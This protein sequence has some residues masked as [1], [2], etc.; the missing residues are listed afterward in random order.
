M[1]NGLMSNSNSNQNNSNKV[2]IKYRFP[3]WLTIFFLLLIL[4]PILIFSNYFAAAKL[5]GIF[6]LILVILALRIWLRISRINSSKVERLVL[7]KNQTFDLER[8]YPFLRTLK[9]VNRQIL[10]HRTGLVLAELAFTSD[11]EI[12]VNEKIELAFNI[13][14]LLFDDEYKSLNGLV[15]KISKTSLDDTISLASIRDL[16]IENVTFSE[17]RA[18]LSKSDFANKIRIKL[19]DL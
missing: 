9:N 11:D 18:K 19:T 4:I 14:I 1:I 10:F 6:C 3:L 5:I 13:S 7:N 8:R 17:Y 15:L 2:Q 12:T 16:T